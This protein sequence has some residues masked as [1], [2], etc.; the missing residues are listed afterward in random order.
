[1]TIKVTY[2]S[3]GVT[4]ITAGYSSGTGGNAVWG[5]IIGT[6]SDQADLQAVLDA[7]VP[8]SGA[9][10]N[11]DLG[12]YELKAGQ[13][14]LDQTPTGVAGVAVTRWN[15]T[16]GTTETTLKGGS[17]VLKHGRDM[18]ERVVNKTG[19]QL[20]RA[21]Y[22]AVRVSTAQGQRLGVALAQANNDNNSADTIGLVV[23]TIDNNQEGYIYTVGEI[24]NINTTGSLQGET[25]VDGDVLYLSPTIAGRITNIK[26]VAPQHLV[27]IGY[28][29]YAHANNGKIYVKVMNGW[30]LGELHDVDTT[31]ATNGQVLK[32]NGTIWTPSGDVG[33]TSLN[34]LTATSQTF[35]T[36]T[37]GTD[38]N[39]S[40]ATSTHTFNLPSASAVNRGLLT[41]ADW[42]TFNNKQNALTNPVTGTGAS[43]QVA[44]WTGTGTQT[45]SNNLFW[46]ATNSRLG[47]G[48]NAPI[49]RLSVLGINTDTITIS[50]TTVEKVVDFKPSNSIG[51]LGFAFNTT[52][53]DVYIYSGFSNGSLIFGTRIAPNNFERMRIT[54]TGNVGINTNNP[55]TNLEVLGGFNVTDGTTTIRAVN[56]GGVA[57]FGTLTNHDLVFRTNNTER[58]RIFANGNFGIGT[59][60]SDNGLRLQVTG[61]GYFSGSV[62]I[63]TTA[64][65]GVTLGLGKN[66]TGNAEGTGINNIGAIQIDVTTS[67]IGFHSRPQISASAFTLSALY[68]HTSREGTS[69]AGSAA[70]ITNQYGY[71]VF[72]LT[73]A[74]N[75]YG[76]YGDIASGTGRWN[77]YMNGTAANYLNGNLGLGTTNPLYKLQVTSSV[78]SALVN[79]N[80][81]DVFIENLGNTGI[82]IGSGTTSNGALVFSDSGSNVAGYLLY[83]H[84]TDSLAFG[85]NASDKMRLDASGNLGLGVTPSAWR[86][87]ERVFQIGLSG[88][89]SAISN[90][91]KMSA[92]VYVDSGNNS[93]Y[94][95]NSFATNY[96]QNLGQHIWY[97]A[98]SGTAGNAITFTQA[99][100]L[101]ASGRLGI[102]TAAP[103]SVLEVAGT[104]ATTDFRISRTISSSIYTYITAPSGTPNTATFGINGTAVFGIN[105]SGNAIF[106]SGSDSGEKL[107]VNGTMRVTGASTFG[108]NVTI[109][110][111]SY[112]APSL[113]FSS[114]SNT[115][116]F[117]PLA[118]NLE[119]KTGTNNAVILENQGVNL[120]PNSENL[121]AFPT[122]FQQ[123]S[124]SIPGSVVAPD[125]KT[126]ANIAIPDTSLNQHRFWRSLSTTFPFTMSVYAKSAGYNF[127]SLGWGGGVSGG[128]IIF[129]IVNGTIS[130]TATDFTATIENVGNGWFRC[131]LAYTLVSTIPTSLSRWIVVRNANSTANYSGDGTSGVY[132][133]G[134]QIEESAAS[135]SYIRTDATTVTRPQAISILGQNLYGNLITRKVGAP[136]LNDF[137]LTTDYTDRLVVKAATG[138]VIVSSSLTAASYNLSALNTAPATASSTGTLGE[139]RIDANYIY[140]CT[141]TNT[142]KRVAIAT[143]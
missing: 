44:Y 85:T 54:A 111:G 24:D 67:Y 47:I 101:D 81:D 16:V 124:V 29:V 91:M 75:N 87:T 129:D 57:L 131:S 48:T 38:F 33:I 130:G 104:A 112:D 46:D 100:T 72:P 139:I 71:Y 53:S 1:M 12:E 26:P 96:L 5:D 99:M 30:E 76:F 50:G 37:S 128:S 82:T 80:Y 143:W 14:E 90:A 69:F 28:V 103:N 62:G 7:K 135:T 52:S 94:I 107:Q 35:A 79:S 120:M 60:A 109:P 125:G 102:G 97:N 137:A 23:E 10:G 25:W 141:A 117:S 105:A 49:S 6:L 68:H 11:V 40:S 43:G 55:S 115:G 142:W 27:V 20:T 8:Y 138:N 19:V 136:S 118:D 89:I 73:K 134:W 110:I 17:V 77:L 3:E 106:G 108:G 15:D 126:N 41:S 65:T 122:N 116:M 132:L 21:A 51:N 127:I 9:T 140:I 123:I 58:A 32:Y 45:G 63:G 22:Q 83:S 64:L 84:G 31:G 114:D 59:G 78:S 113:S 18:F 119:I 66:I 121:G 98:P 133:W 42:T 2:N 4:Y 86:S 56:S 95:N 36:G 34:S 70:T 61:D 93:L 74:T 88:S 39:I 13:L 92:N